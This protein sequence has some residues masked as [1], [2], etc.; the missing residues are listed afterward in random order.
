MRPTALLAGAQRRSVCS[1]RSLPVDGCFRYLVNC[2]RNV[3]AV[4]IAPVRAG[5]PD[6]VC[7]LFAAAALLGCLLVSCQ[8]AGGHS[9]RLLQQPSYKNLLDAAQRCVGLLAA[10]PIIVGQ[11]LQRWHSLASAQL[12]IAQPGP[13][14]PWGAS[15]LH[16]VPFARHILGPGAVLVGCEDLGASSC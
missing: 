7:F 11:P 16:L 8:A 15:H 5:E 10:H 13:W 6:P 9:R 14:D 3:L 4:I 2:F 12:P 1:R